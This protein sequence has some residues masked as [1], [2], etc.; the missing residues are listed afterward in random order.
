MISDATVFS[1]DRKM[2]GMSLLVRLSVRKQTARRYGRPLLGFHLA[3]PLSLVELDDCLS[4][5]DK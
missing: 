5:W 3:R 1:S 4:A 2:T